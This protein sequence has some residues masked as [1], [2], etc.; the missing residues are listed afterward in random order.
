MGSPRT[1]TQT[2]TSSADFWAIPPLCWWENGKLPLA[3]T[4]YVGEVQRELLVIEEDWQ[5]YRQKNTEKVERLVCRFNSLW[6]KMYLCV[7]LYDKRDQLSPQIHES[8]LQLELNYICNLCFHL[9]HSENLNWFIFRIDYA[10]QSK[11]VTITKDK[12]S[13]DVTILDVS[14]IFV[15]QGVKLQLS[16]LMSVTQV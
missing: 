4:S 2:V 11:Y 16:I 7:E 1:A 3:A 9:F 15:I 6:G 8:V 13:H 10:L 5:R 14:R 12:E